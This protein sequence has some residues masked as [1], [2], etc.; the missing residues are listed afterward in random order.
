MSEATDPTPT[1]DASESAAPQL[2]AAEAR[3]V[4]C[5]IEKEATTPDVYPLTLNAIVT[6]CNQKTAREPTMQLEQGEIANAL[7]RLEPRGWVKSQ[8]TARAERYSHRAAAVLDLT[9]PQAALVALL[10]LRGPQTAYELLSR[11]ERLAK[12]DSVG[13][14]QYALERLAQ[15]SPP[16]VRMLG[17]QSGQREDR[18]GHLLSGEPVWHGSA[19]DAGHGD[20]GGSAEAQSALVER[21]EALEAKLAELEARLEAAGA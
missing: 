11:S 5:L 2:S 3:I 15:H 9:R 12:F 4:A 17:R 16:L 14:V 10:M 20:G 13:D 19:H 21:I 6:A 7:R 18:Y 8:H 1:Q